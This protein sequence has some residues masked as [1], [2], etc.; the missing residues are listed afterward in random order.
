M[1][2]VRPAALLT[3]IAGLVLVSAPLSIAPASAVGDGSTAPLRVTISGVTPGEIPTTKR[4]RIVV[5]GSVRNTTKQTWRDVHVYPLTSYSPIT[6]GPD[7]AD[8]AAS[9][10]TSVIGDRLVDIGRTVGTLRP[11]ER[12][13]FRIRIPIGT[14]KISHEPGVYW[15]AVHALGSGRDGSDQVADGRA[16][17]FVPLV[18]KR[19]AAPAPVSLVV[20]LI[21]PI[22]RTA[23]GRIANARTLARAT[24]P[25]G[26]LDRLL[27][28]A[29]SSGSVS[30]T[31]VV[32]PAVLDAV[33][34]LIDGNPGMDLAR[35]EPNA[36]TPSGA[37]TDPTTAGP[38]DTDGAPGPS[39]TDA[40]RAATKRWLEDW[41]TE[42]RLDRVLALPYGN[43]DVSSMR[44]RYRGLLAQ[45]W[46][47]TDDVM[48]ELKITAGHAVDPPDGYLRPG[49]AALLGGRTT[50]LL[51]DH[52]RP[53]P[54][55]STDGSDYVYTSSGV[56]SGGPRPGNRTSSLQLRQR[57]LA[58]ASLNVRER[59][60]QPL[61]VQLPAD[62][63]PG[64]PGATA[65]FFAGFTAP[66][67]TSTPVPE[68]ANT[69]VAPRLD[70]TAR[71]ADSLLPALNLA[72]A[73]Q[74]NRLADTTADLFTDDTDISRTVRVTALTAT[75]AY[76]RAEPVGA[77]VDVN[78][79]Q[80]RMEALLDDIQVEGTDFVVLSGGSGALTVAVHNGLDQPIKV[81]LRG[82][83]DDPRITF[84]APSAIKL[85]AGSR[86]TVRLHA[87]AR[88]V[89]VHE[90][91]LRA[92]TS[93]D[94]P[95]GRPLVF[96]VRTSQIGRVF[97]LVLAGAT[98][99]LVL[100]V[101]RRVRMRIRARRADS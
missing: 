90:V 79:A 56:A 62:W 71:A 92:V 98:V 45:A 96:S 72:A 8:A 22:T 57:L 36:A 67:V 75:S 74:V 47:L 6:S 13:R 29:R 7:L 26:R 41:T 55:I 19:F 28:F 64:S 24:A 23:D 12:S 39:L 53:H 33:R 37:P 44:A 91:T 43:V 94:H 54:A 52:G 4:G 101:A 63:R 27:D 20:P 35:A 99:L 83:A 49:A 97:W 48:S 30:I 95:V 31:W 1:T 25:G 3:V 81:G 10:P 40:D 16:R 89:G 82:H 73:R 60:T 87:H 59:R 70:W 84:D 65:R 21:E 9:D 77:R 80:T 100:L 61:V 32:D 2:R 38:D 42:A 86:A 14:L 68:G 93:A 46:Q 50:V 78:S 76:A 17:T 18:R 58:E 69:G 15:L 11:G 66:W 5:S 85:A 34:Q 88:T 51:Q